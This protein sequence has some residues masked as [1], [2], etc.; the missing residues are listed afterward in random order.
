KAEIDRLKGLLF[1]VNRI[2][3]APP[4]RLVNEWSVRGVHQANNA[5]IHAAG[6]VRSQVGEFEFLAECRN[7]RRSRRRIDTLRESRSCWRR[8]RN[9]DPDE[10]ILFFACVTARVDA[11]DSEF[12]IGGQRRNHLALAGVG[13]EPPAVIT[14]FQLAAVEPSAGKRHAAM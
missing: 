10:A 7:A 6:Q 13:V 2:A 14:A 3:A 5:V 1:F 4:P 11:I 9:E 8:L 12:L